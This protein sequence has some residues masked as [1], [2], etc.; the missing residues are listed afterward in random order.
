[1]VPPREKKFTPTQVSLALT[2]T[3]MTTAVSTDSQGHRPL[4]PT[5]SM[6]SLLQL[7]LLELII[8]SNFSV[9]QPEVKVIDQSM[10][11]LLK[12]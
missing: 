1:M 5:Q 6:V 10:V 9:Y 11:S 7:Q 8:V 2:H 3:G 12:L 4:D